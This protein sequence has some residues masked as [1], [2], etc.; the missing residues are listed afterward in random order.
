MIKGDRIKG[1]DEKDWKI[2]GSKDKDGMNK[3]TRNEGSQ[4]WQK[5]V[6][7]LTQTRLRG[8][9]TKFLVRFNENWH[10]LHPIFYWQCFRFSIG[11]FNAAEILFKLKFNK[12][13]F[14]D[15]IL[16]NLRRVSLSKQWFGFSPNW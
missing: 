4:L 10:Y 2:K 12:R 9:S 6:C 3:K 15:D 7:A 16:S 1:K 5:T 13:I 11:L 14:K 8:E